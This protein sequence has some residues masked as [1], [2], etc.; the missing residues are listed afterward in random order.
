MSEINIK[1]TE[2][3]TGETKNIN[4]SGYL[5]LSLDQDKIKMQGKLDIKSL[6]PILTRIALEKLGK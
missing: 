3:E 2:I 5:L 1:I 4:T 6:T